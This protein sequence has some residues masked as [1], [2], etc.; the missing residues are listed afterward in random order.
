MITEF[1]HINNEP[2]DSGLGDTLF[3]AMTKV[4]DN[5][6]A[7][8]DN[9]SQIGHTH[10]IS[11]IQG[12]QTALTDLLAQINDM[13][14]SALS[15]VALSTLSN[16]ETLVWN[17]TTSKWENSWSFMQ[18]L[19]GFDLTVKPELLNPT[20]WQTDGYKNYKYTYSFGNRYRKIT[21]SPLLKATLDEF[22]LEQAL[23]T[24]IKKRKL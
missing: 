24:L 14:L 8:I 3:A 22:Y 9:F 4:N 19:T 11:E 17:S 20:T 18:Y 21:Y 23:T 15:D 16:D 12:L 13:E 2:Q 6:E 10:T 5:F 7:V 1:I